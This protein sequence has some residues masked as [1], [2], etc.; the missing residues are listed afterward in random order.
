MNTRWLFILMGAWIAIQTAR[1]DDFE[2][3]AK[4]LADYARPKVRTLS[5]DAHVFHWTWAFDHSS[6]PLQP[7]DH[8]LGEYA[9]YLKESFW[10]PATNSDD[11][12]GPGL[13]VAIDPLASNAFGNTLLQLVMPAGMPFLATDIDYFPPDL[14]ISINRIGCL[15]SSIRDVF[16]AA[17]NGEQKPCRTLRHKL[18]RDLGVWAIRYYWQSEL[19]R[20]CNG[21]AQYAF[22]L[23]DDRAINASR[24]VA[25]PFDPN[26]RKNA[27]LPPEDGHGENRL[28]LNSMALK[29]YGDT[30]QF[31]KVPEGTQPKTDIDAWMRD[32]LVGCG[33]YP[34]DK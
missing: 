16:G 17:E 9:T 24:I 13:Y 4:A 34:E 12:V 2:D 6:P 25:F 8:R 5:R 7:M 23:Y 27:S 1:A 10:D 26:L 32:N 21:S 15:A 22:V 30:S 19:S 18:V 11:L 31:W 14:Q 29:A 20:L 33:N 28:I 3:A